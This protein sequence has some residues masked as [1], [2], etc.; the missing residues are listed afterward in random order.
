MHYVKEIAKGVTRSEKRPVRR[1]VTKFFTEGAKLAR[2]PIYTVLCLPA[3]AW[4]TEKMINRSFAA[5][6]ASA[7]RRKGL[8]DVQMRFSGFERRRKLLPK[9]ILRMPK[10]GFLSCGDIFDYRGTANAAWFDTCGTVTIRTLD[11]M[12]K[13]IKRNKSKAGRREL[14]VRVAYTFVCARD[15]WNNDLRKFY[16]ESENPRIDF[17]Q[18]YLRAELNIEGFKAITYQ[19]RSRDSAG[20]KMV[21]VMF[22]A[23]M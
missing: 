3:V 9:S 18:D 1:A 21:T 8:I 15:P 11:R 20:S 22:I 14:P 19:S 2:S 23:R 4:E 13:V 7:R 17:V 5:M 12:I 6:L 16:P 10:N